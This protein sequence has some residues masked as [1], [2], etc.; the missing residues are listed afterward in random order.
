MK[1]LPALLA[2]IVVSFPFPSA[3]A[4]HSTSAEFDMSKTVAI[5]GTICG[6]EFSNPHSYIYVH[7]RLANG[8]AETWKLEL[9]GAA[10]MTQQTVP[11][12]TFKPGESI[13]IQA[14]ASKAKP[15]P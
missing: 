12:E 3:Y 6:G 13:T 14:Y 8:P 5:T 10:R 15:S 4:H 7:V 11:K 9:P 2:G 1:R